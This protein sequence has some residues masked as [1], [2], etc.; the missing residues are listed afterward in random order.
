MVRVKP[1]RGRKRAAAPP[2]CRSCGYLDLCPHLDAR[3]GVCRV[4]E[5]KRVDQ[6]VEGRRQGD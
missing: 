4:D 2:V 5:R 6:A 3:R 1:K